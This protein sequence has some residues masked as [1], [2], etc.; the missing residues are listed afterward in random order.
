MKYYQKGKNAFK[1]AGW[2]D[3][4][5]IWYEEHNKNKCKYYNNVLNTSSKSGT[6]QLHYY[7]CVS[8]TKKIIT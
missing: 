5:R 4:F 6:S 1:C 8:S 3:F 2:N 7:L